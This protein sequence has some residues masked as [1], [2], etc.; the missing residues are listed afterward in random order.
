MSD[1]KTKRLSGAQ[2][3]KRRLEKQK[4]TEKLQGSLSKFLCNPSNQTQPSTQNN[5][6]EDMEVDD[7]IIIDHEIIE[8]TSTTVT[9]STNIERLEEKNGEDD[10][11]DE[12]YSSEKSI[13]VSKRHY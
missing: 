7:V 9:V 12:V 3:K 5:V 4:T 1:R 2:Y 6:R 8:S 11:D 13:E 10:N